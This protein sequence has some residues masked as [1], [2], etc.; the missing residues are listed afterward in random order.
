MTNDIL[1]GMEGILDFA[2]VTTVEDLTKS[3]ARMIQG[4]NSRG[5]P[6]CKIAPFYGLVG[7]TAAILNHQHSN[8]KHF[9]D[10]IIL[11]ALQ[12]SN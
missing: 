11:R 6:F 12:S 4:D 8:L 3:I 9:S 5:V 1:E 10:S 2:N 7:K